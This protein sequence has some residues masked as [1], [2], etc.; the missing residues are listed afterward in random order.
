MEETEKT[1]LVVD[2]TETNIDLIVDFLGDRYD[3]MVALDGPSAL[4]LVEED[5][6]DMILL[7]VMMPGMD[8]FEVCDILKKNDKTRN[9]PVVMVTALNDVKDR[10][11]ALEVGADDFLNKPVDPSELMARVKSSL[12]V[13]ALRDKEMAYL[14]VIEEEKAKSDALL[15]NVLPHSIAERLKQGE[16]LIA[17]NHSEATILFL[18]IVGFTTLS[19]K[20]A[21]SELVQML[22]SIFD[23]I[24][25][26]TEKHGLEKIKTI[27]D[28]YMIAAGL[29]EYRE[30]QAQVAADFALEVVEAIEEHEESFVDSL[31]I[32]VGIHCGPVT[33]GVI[34]KK[35][36]LYDLWGDAVNT[37]S[38]ME[39][40]GEPGKI[41]VSEAIYQKLKDS[42]AFEDRGTIAVKGKGEMSTYFL[43][44]KN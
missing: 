8:G 33:A 22:S 6:P 31:Q 28:A 17:D 26:L 36:F 38:R 42:Y 2:D 1:I 10:V 18:D 30:D 16:S 11:K 34:G 41:H 43:V 25:G 21:A 13:K 19:S 12:E 3:I 27:G 37:A 29:P 40:H 35:R 15:H 4:E 7:D 39:S 20:I 9:I 32:R 5:P 14:K 44:G 23:K 24:D